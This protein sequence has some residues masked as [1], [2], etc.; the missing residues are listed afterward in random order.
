MQPTLMHLKVLL[1]FQ[2]FTEKQA[3]SRIVAETREGS[4][5]LLPH[6][7]D[8]VA[9]LVPGILIYENEEE[10]EVYVAIDEGVLIK[11]GLD[12]VISVR[13]AIAGTNLSELREAVDKEF[14]DLNAQEQNV[15]SVMTKMESGFI[16]RLAEFHHE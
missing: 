16:R 11:I 7:L 12:V 6:R 14:L 1:P 8:C 3:V 4:F 13:N 15:R 10:G 5:G 2:I 9:A